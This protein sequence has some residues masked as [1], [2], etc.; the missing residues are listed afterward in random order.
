MGEETYYQQFESRG[1]S[2]DR[3]MRRFP[4]A[5]RREFMQVVSSVD[6]SPGMTV[7]DVPAGGG[8]LEDYLPPGCVYYGHEPC[9]SFTSHGDMDKSSAAGLVPLPWADKFADVLVSIAGV[10]H[11]ENKRNLLDEMA[12]VVKPTGFLVISDVA[13]NSAVSQFLDRYVGAHNST[14]HVGMYLTEEIIYQ[15]IGSAWQI[16][17]VR[18]ENFHWVFSSLSMMTSFCH[19]LFDL[20][21]TSFDK[22]EKAIESTLG[23]DKLSDGM[24]GMRWSL[25]TVVAQRRQDR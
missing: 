24:V 9:V 6:I 19:D 8:Y 5:R 7:A 3:A 2:Y 18:H 23:I 1:A 11:V 25:M 4:H 20:R 14:G 17:S 13:A 12:R 10:H 15:V 16:K 22:T 21:T